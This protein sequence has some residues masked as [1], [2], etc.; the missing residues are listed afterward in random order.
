MDGVILYSNDG[1]EKYQSAESHYN[2]NLHTHMSYSTLEVEAYGVN[3]KESQINL[4]NAFEL[5][6]ADLQN[7]I[8]TI[9]ESI[10]NG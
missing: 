2:N 6:I 3:L 8:T 10:L 5:I 9:N 4:V 7:K 1:K